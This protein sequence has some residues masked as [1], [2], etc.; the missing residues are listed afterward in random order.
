MFGAKADAA[1]IRAPSNFCRSQSVEK[2]RKQIKRRENMKTT[3]GFSKA[4]CQRRHTKWYERWVHSPGQRAGPA[5]NSWLELGDSVSMRGQSPRSLVLFR[6]LG[7]E[8]TVPS[9]H[10]LPPT[11]LDRSHI[12]ILQIDIAGKAEGFG[13]ISHI[14]PRVSHNPVISTGGVIDVN[15]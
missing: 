7:N 1:V 14:R 12:A 8:G 13:S 11:H 4:T 15:R 10:W 5:R 3:R 9:F 2:A 6:K